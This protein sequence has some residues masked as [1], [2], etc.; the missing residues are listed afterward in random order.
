MAVNV[1]GQGL[2]W[3]VASVLGVAVADVAEQWAWRCL[4]AMGALPGCTLLLV[5]KWLPVSL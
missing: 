2:G 1:L 5:L 3:L 4:F